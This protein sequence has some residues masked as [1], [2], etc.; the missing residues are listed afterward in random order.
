M[1]HEE[2]PLTD[3]KKELDSV[4]EIIAY[5][6]QDIN[7]EETDRENP[8]H[9]A[10]KRKHIYTIQNLLDDN[11]DVNATTSNGSNSFHLAC[12]YADADTLYLLI[13]RGGDVNAKDDE[14]KTPT[15]VA[16]DNR[17]DDCIGILASAG[18]NLDEKNHD[19]DSPLIV[20]A[21]NGFSSTVKEL[22]VNGALF[23]VKDGNGKN[24]LQR[25][26]MEKS[27][28]AAANIIRLVLQ[29]EYLKR[30]IDD[31]E[32]GL[33]KIIRCEMKETMKALLDHALVQHPK[34]PH[35]A[36]VKTEYFDIHIAD[37]NHKSS[38]KRNVFLKRLADLVDDDIA[39]NGT[40]RILVERKMKKIGN[41]F[42]VFK[43]IFHFFFMIALSYSL[44]QASY[45]NAPEAYTINPANII[46][47]FAELYVLFYF[48][49][50]F[51][52]EGFEFFK[53]YKNRIVLNEEAGQKKATAFVFLQTI[54]EYFSDL[55]N[56]FDIVGLFSLLILIILRFTSQ[57]AQWEF[58][59]ITNV[60][61][62]LR[63]FQVIALVPFIG[64]YV[65]TFFQI[66][67]CEV[68]QFVGGFLL[69]LFMFAT[70]YFIALRTPYTAEGFRNQSL[71]QDTDRVPGIDNEF[72]WTFVSGVRILL[73]GNLYDDVYVYQHLNWSAALLYMSFLFLTV[74]IFLNVFI[75]QLSDSYSVVR[76]NAN[77]A[78]AWHRLT[79]VVQ[80]QKQSLFGFLN[81]FKRRHI[82]G[83]ITIDKDEMFEYYGVSC[84][85]NLN[86]KHY[87]ED[88]EVKESLA[89]IQNQQ[90]FARKTR[91]I[92]AE[93]IKELNVK[94][95]NLTESLDNLVKLVQEKLK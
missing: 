56:Y 61:N 28:G 52:S 34:K 45:E 5:V 12:E 87:T 85:Q 94:I 84:I 53:I 81:C 60:I 80:I 2:I 93:K 70:S 11:A 69:Y 50:N 55:T 62:S 24:A 63:L 42:L 41:L 75:A 78:Y 64:P 66:L 31:P 29:D 3:I 86:T 68:P 44:I 25:A 54:G 88:V 36:L 57:P 74:V 72:Y 23:E 22:I 47:I 8:L 37:K 35:L 26:I 10:I 39:Y 51:A 21:S 43:L 30:Y 76:E 48:A 1:A 95:D 33:L 19:G 6:N 32:V 4:P 79:F 27:D 71:M 18:A 83:D 82:I 46:R 17:N 16:V 20:A 92:G 13:T 77:R 67:K 58:A 65:N 9:N 40:V 14:G 7:T 73:E 15:M 90:L 49:Y 91:E 89:S 59:T 38:K